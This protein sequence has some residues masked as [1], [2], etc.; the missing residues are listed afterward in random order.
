MVHTIVGIMGPDKG[1]EKVYEIAE[2]L[3]KACAEKGYTVLTGGRSRGVMDAAC[4]GAKAAGGTTI[5]I[6]PGDNPCNDV[7]PHVD[8]PIITGL[9]SARDNINVLT[10]NIVVAVGMGPGTSAEVSLALKAGKHTVLLAG[11]EEAVKFFTSLSPAHVHVAADV[12]AALAHIDS[13]RPKKL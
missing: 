6:I 11:P 5:G 3:G 1:G 7:S 13:L 4:K 10:S 8:I 12:G 2:A 9:G